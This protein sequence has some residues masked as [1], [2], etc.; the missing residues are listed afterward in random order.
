MAV[1]VVGLVE[2]VQI[3]HC[4]AQRRVVARSTRQ[5]ALQQ[6]FQATAVQCLGERV[7]AGQIAGRAQFLLQ[8]GD[9]LLGTLYFLPRVGQVV[10]RLRRLLLH[11]AGVAHHV[12]QQ[13]VEVG[14]AARFAQL[15][16]VAADA[17]VVLAGAGSHAIHALDELAHQ[18]A[19]RC[20]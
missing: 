10:A 11:L 6:F 15:Q 17:I 5:L 2:V 8:L 20:L 1:R 7:D 19:H 3:D 18:P 13:L 9:A 14:D 12:L 16:R 4:H